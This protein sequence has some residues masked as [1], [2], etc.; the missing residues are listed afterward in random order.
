MPLFLFPIIWGNSLQ[1][2]ELNKNI[3]LGIMIG[4][5]LLVSKFNELKE[6]LSG[7]NMILYNKISKSEFSYRLYENFLSVVSEELYF[8]FLIIELMAISI[9]RWSILLSAT[10]F[11]F[12]H[13]LNRWADKMFS[14][15]SYIYHMLVGLSLG[16][17]YYYTNSLIGCI[18]AHFIFNSSHY[19]L[20][21]KRMKKREYTVTFD[22]YL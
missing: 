19:I 12:S 21:Y 13:W 14:V 10:L 9:G 18:L 17:Y 22:D 16:V 4:V 1:S 7:S 11:T 20:D 6:I 5:I 2:F 8:R 3:L 15:R